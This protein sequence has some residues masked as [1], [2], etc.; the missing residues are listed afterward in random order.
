MLIIRNCRILLSRSFYKHK[1]TPILGVLITIQIILESLLNSLV[2]ATG[3]EPET[4]NTQFG[5]FNQPSKT[6][7]NKH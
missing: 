3:F 5:I 1:K 7:Q 4:L 2:A 6:L